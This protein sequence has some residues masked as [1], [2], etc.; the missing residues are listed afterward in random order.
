M[1]KPNKT[2]ITYFRVHLRHLVVLWRFSSSFYLSFVVWK[3]FAVR[4]I[5]NSDCQN[6]WYS[7]RD[8]NENINWYSEMSSEESILPWIRFFLESSHWKSDYN[9]GYCTR[10]HF[11]Y[12]EKVKCDYSTSPFLHHTNQHSHRS[13]IQ[14]KVQLLIWWFECQLGI[15]FL[16]LN[17]AMD[18]IFLLFIMKWSMVDIHVVWLSHVNTLI[19]IAF[20]ENRKPQTNSLC[21]HCEH[22]N[23]TIGWRFYFY[24]CYRCL[25]WTLS[26]VQSQNP[27]L[28]YQR[29]NDENRIEYNMKFSTVPAVT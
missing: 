27:A 28:K 5:V 14:A 22:V 24:C 1:Q 15:S 4:A 3:C 21:E 9:K 20:H 25:W 11:Q 8:R 29:M 7:V 23:Q 13:Q 12:D 2:E 10:W 16:Q 26:S 19:I 18:F 17:I 6:C